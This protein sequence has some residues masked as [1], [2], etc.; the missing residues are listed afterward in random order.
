[1]EEKMKKKETVA[2]DPRNDTVF[3]A[4]FS[5]DSFESTCARNKLIEAFLGRKVTQSHL[6][7][8]ELPIQ[9]QGDKA[10]TLD[11]HCLLE[12]KTRVN[13]EM[14]FAKTA[15]SIEARV[16][17]YLV[18]LAS[19]QKLRGKIYSEIHDTYVILI[20]DKT[21]YKDS[22]HL[23]HF[24]FSSVGGR[25]ICPELNIIMLEL[26]K[27]RE[28]DILI[29]ELNPA[30]KWGLYFS[31]AKNKKKQKV[32]Q[33]IMKDE[34]GI[35]MANQVLEGITQEDID[36]S[37]SFLQWQLEYKKNVLITEALEEGRAEGLEQGLEKLRQTARSMKA[38]GLPPEQIKR[39][40]GLSEDEY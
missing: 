14:Q 6:M 16:G 2:V 33:K 22:E 35:Q 7:N 32:I 20:S 38:E 17:H 29:E 15:D 9:N 10:I 25:K 5:Q 12:D 27:L 24:R 11:L 34:E 26:Q 36:A 4:L 28:K 1:M 8:N 40:T 23:A 13:I 31:Y 30:E 18:R 37:V 39:F 21:L 19:L 3:K